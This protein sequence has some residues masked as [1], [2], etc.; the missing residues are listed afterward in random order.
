MPRR[1]RRK[2]TPQTIAQAARMAGKLVLTL[3][4]LMAVGAF[5]WSLRVAWFVRTSDPVAATAQAVEN[6]HPYTFRTQYAYDWHGEPGTFEWVEPTA[7]EI[8]A[9]EAV[10]IS[11]FDGSD[12]RRDRWTLWLGPLLV[13]ASAAFKT[14]LGCV[15]LF[16]VPRLVAGDRAV[17]RTIPPAR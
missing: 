17:P 13:L 7:P 16:V 8:G 6:P 3:A 10:R 4:A 12:I 9:V 11:R 2:A 1:P 14:L 5:L 15:S